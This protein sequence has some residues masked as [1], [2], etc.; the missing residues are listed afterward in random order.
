MLHQHVSANDVTQ[1][2]RMCVVWDTFDVLSALRPCGRSQWRPLP[3]GGGGGGGEDRGRA[4]H[5]AAGSRARSLICAGDVG[6]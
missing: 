5:R 4:H 1:K 3:R 6:C 2:H